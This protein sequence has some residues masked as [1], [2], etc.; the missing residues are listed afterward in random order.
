MRICKIGK[1]S[2][3]LNK[4]LYYK[5]IHLWDDTTLFDNKK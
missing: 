4:I 3:L 5:V 2:T 1:P